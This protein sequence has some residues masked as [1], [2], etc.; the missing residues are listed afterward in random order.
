MLPGGW[1]FLQTC[2]M[3]ESVRPLGQVGRC[4]RRTP[5][6]SSILVKGQDRGSLLESGGSRAEVLLCQCHIPQPLP[7]ESRTALEM[8]V[9]LGHAVVAP[10]GPPA[11]G[12]VH[13]EE[14]VGKQSVL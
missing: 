6:A 12:C 11:R 10:R 7:A 13:S 4:T 3:W 1:F 9:L 14:L 8:P 2:T 5:T